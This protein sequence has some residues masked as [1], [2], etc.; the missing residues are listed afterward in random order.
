MFD[1]SGSLFFFNYERTGL[2]NILSGSKSSAVT[3]TDSVILKLITS[4]TSKLIIRTIT[5]SQHSLGNNLFMS[6]AYSA[7]FNLHSDDSD[8][9]PLIMASASKGVIFYPY[10]QSL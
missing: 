10:W 3:G 1:I 8:F 7:S 4:G 5:G 6:G 9:V 2:K